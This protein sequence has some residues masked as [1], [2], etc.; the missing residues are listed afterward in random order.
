MGFEDDQHNP[1]SSSDETEH[2]LSSGNDEMPLSAESVE[3]YVQLHEH[4]E[5]LREDR[6]PRQPAL[7]SPDEASVYQMAALFRAAAP[8]ASE[9]DPAFVRSLR[10]QLLREHQSN[11]AAS[12]ETDAVIPV[13]EKP[14]K[15]KVS[16]RVILGAG[17]STAAAAVVGVAAGAAIEHTM[18]PNPQWQAG[19]VPLV[20]DGT[21][22]WVAVAQ[23][24]AIPVGG[25]A[26]FATDYI[27][28]F[29][30]HT[31]SGFS[32]L[33]GVCTHMACLLNWNAGDR[34]FDCPCHGGRFAENGASAS[35]SPVAYK[36]L[37]TI[38]TRVEAG[39]IWVYVVPPL[40]TDN[41]PGPAQL[42]HGAYGTKTPTT[43]P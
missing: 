31:A 19:D 10:S 13:T 20:P 37:P 33:S 42:D 1:T 22:V 24:D 32:A 28:G 43:K 27:V 14:I 5:R 16:R 36:P 21:G 18:Q 3:Q 41:T 7:N 35:S 17:L 29:I 39:Q 40:S 8:D 34:T 12:A 11:L 25:V 9:P 30:R 4:I 2:T 6:R 23:A 38:K 26:H 15:G